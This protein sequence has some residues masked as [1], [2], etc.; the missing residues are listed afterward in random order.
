MGIAC[1]IYS[2]DPISAGRPQPA[3]TEPMEELLPPAHAQRHALNDELHRHSYEPLHP[4]E[5]IVYLSMLV[6][7]EERLREEAHL[8]ELLPHHS[9][10][11]VETSANSI[12]YDF[13]AF[14]LKLE[15]HIEFTRYKFVWKSRL[16]HDKTPFPDSLGDLLPRDWLS[17][18]P[19]RLLSG[20]NIALLKYPADASDASLIEHHSASFDPNRFSASRVGRSGGLAM[21]DFCIKEDGLIPLLVFTKAHLPTQNGRL[22]LRLLEIDTYRSLAML[23][24]PAARSILNDLPALENELAALSE[25]V[26]TGDG[27]G[28]E[29]LLEELTSI[30]ARVERMT[31]ANARHL[32]ASAAYFNLV[33]FRLKELREEP[34][35]QVA[36]IGGFLER[37]LEP[38]RTTCETAASRLGQ[39]S[40]RIAHASQLLLTRIEVRREIHNQR[41]LVSMNENFQSQLSLQKA[42][43]LLSFVIVPYYGVNLLTYLLEEIG[44]LGG[45]ATDPQTIKALGVPVIIILMLVV[46]RRVHRASGPSGQ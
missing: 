21:T 40:H 20:M 37:R 19:G 41:L 9:A 25:A 26:A 43:E 36:S 46:L 4:P 34:I 30:A 14:R 29:P 45:I 33:S 42:A 1:V 7:P 18:L 15:R 2:A 35:P 13:G 17:R 8:Q 12:R 38:A 10:L 23:P 24:L 16:P 22:I 27:E 6:T 44:E 5:R 11:T 32:S 3:E 39:L 28:D 31:A